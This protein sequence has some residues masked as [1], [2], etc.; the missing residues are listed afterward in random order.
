MGTGWAAAAA[1]LLLA[2]G[3]PQKEAK[4]GAMEAPPSQIIEDFRLTETVEGRLSYDLNAERAYVYEDANRIDVTKPRV[5]FF[6]D[7]RCLTSSV[8]ADAGSVNSKTSDLVARGNV[9]VTTKDSTN[10][11]TDSLVWRNKEQV[12][13]TD[14][15]V[16]MRGP[17]GSIRGYGLVSD[18]NLKRIEIKNTVQATTTYEFQQPAVKEET[19]RRDT[20]PE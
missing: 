12:I 1:L 18:A 5:R 8:T 15:L 6:D 14:A 10:L 3:C 19:S 11:A 7:Q 9:L 2:A 16:D 17:Q 13:T 20:I 4:K